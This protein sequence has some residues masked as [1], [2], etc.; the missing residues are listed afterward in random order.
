MATYTVMRRKRQTG[1]RVDVV[2][3][4]G[5]RHTILGFDTEAEA[6]AWIEKDQRL[7]AFRQLGAAA[8]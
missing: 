5:S 4:D 2:G 6:Q 1:Y 3:D 8:D 7:E